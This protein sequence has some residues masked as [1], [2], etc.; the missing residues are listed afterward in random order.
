[1]TNLPKKKND[2]D[3]MIK[4]MEAM[5]SGKLS[6]RRAAE[7]FSVNKVLCMILLGKKY[8]HLGKPGRKQIVPPDVDK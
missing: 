8:Q 7:G 6:L 2:N 3:S 4:A 1:M 5:S